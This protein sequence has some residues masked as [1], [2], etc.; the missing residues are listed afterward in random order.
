MYDENLVEQTMVQIIESLQ[1]EVRVL[2]EQSKVTK[3]KVSLEN[4]FRLP[5]L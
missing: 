4:I 2:R 3:Q 5:W 1:E